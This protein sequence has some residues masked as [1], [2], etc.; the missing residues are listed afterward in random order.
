MEDIHSATRPDTILHPIRVRIVLAVQ[1]RRLTTA[2]IHRLLPDVP[3]PTLY[4][5][6]NRLTEAG[7]VQI[8]EPNKSA[9][10]TNESTPWYK[11]QQT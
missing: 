4:R 11:R 3:L 2:Q 7:I 8:V 6:L 5:H 10:T 1:G 9:V